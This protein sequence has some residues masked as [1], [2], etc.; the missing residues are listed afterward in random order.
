MFLALCLSADQPI[1]ISH[2]SAA[3]LH[4]IDQIVPDRIHLTR[5]SEIKSAI[6]RNADLVQIHKTEILD[7]RDFTM[8][9]GIPVTSVARTII[10]LAEYLSPDSLSVVI[11]RA[12]QE[13]RVCLEDLHECYERVGRWRGRK[14]FKPI[15]ENLLYRP[16][17]SKAES[18]LERRIEKIVQSP[19]LPAPKPQYPVRANGSYYRL[20]FAYPKFKIAIE[21]DGF[22]NHRERTSFVNDRRRINNLLVAGWKIIHFT[23]ES[24]EFE[25]LSTLKSL[26]KRQVA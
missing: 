15:K 16:M 7:Q 14:L 19:D 22:A 24:N 12:L 9:E 6:K 8:V 13:Q 11:D 3:E 5:S 17:H 10:D 26:L 18:G 1:W 23:S 2:S 25:I 21:V 4:G 20:D